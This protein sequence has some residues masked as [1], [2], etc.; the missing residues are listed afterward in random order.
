MC[1]NKWDSVDFNHVPSNAMHLY[2]KSKITLKKTKS[3]K[4]RHDDAVA[5]RPGA[6]MRH[7]SERFTQWREALKTGKIEN[8]DGTVVKV[9]VNAAQLFP[10]EVVSRFLVRVC[11]YKDSVR[12]WFPAWV[13]FDQKCSN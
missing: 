2:G 8:E 12:K 3:R 5:D 13:V 10:H 4:R 7:C 9:K 11:L 6:F 1:Q